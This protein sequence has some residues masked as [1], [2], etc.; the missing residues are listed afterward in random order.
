MQPSRRWPLPAQFARERFVASFAS[1]D[2]ARRNWSRRIFGAA[3]ASARGPGRLEPLGHRRLSG[4]LGS[5]GPAV[6]QK[7]LQHDSAQHALG[8]P[9]SI[10]PAKCCRRAT[11]FATMAIRSSSARPRRKHGLEVH[12]WKV[13]FNL[14]GGPQ[15]FVAQCV[16]Q[17]RTQVSV[18]G[19]ALDWLCPS[20][21]DNQR[22]ELDALVEVARKY[23]VAGLHLDY[24]RYPDEECCYCEGCRRRFE[25]AS[26][27]RVTHWPEDC[28][29][30]PRK[31]EYNDWRCRQITQLVEAVHR[32]VKRIRPEMKLSAAVWGGYPDCRRTVAQDWPAWVR[33]GYLD[34]VCPMDYTDDDAEFAEWVRQQVQWSRGG[35]RFTP[36][37]ARRPRTCRSRPIAWWGRFS[38]ARAQAPRASVFSTS[39]MPRPSAL[40]PASGWVWGACRRLRR[41]GRKWRKVRAGS[42]VKPGKWPRKKPC[43][44]AARRDIIRPAIGKP[45]SRRRF[46]PRMPER[47][48]AIFA[49][50][51]LRKDLTWK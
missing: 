7:R 4:R 29:R 22:L 40:C 44:W 48:R 15:D 30:G 16:S 27:R 17:H 18:R 34:F 31:E 25:A 24:I 13:C 6:G 21:P 36:A 51:Q 11:S 12:V 37:L 8:R 20:H 10:T 38:A 43:N 39:I 9:G 33:A 19:R 28:F 50:T 5:L 23:R 41:T 3:V 42:R 14:A 1:A 2:R 47:H 32:E 49:F 46:P 45:S 35:F 26:G